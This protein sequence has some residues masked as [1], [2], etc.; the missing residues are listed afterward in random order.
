MEKTEPSLC[1]LCGEPLPHT[2]TMEDIRNSA[3]YWTLATA[4]L[5]ELAEELSAINKKPRPRRK[6]K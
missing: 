5:R 4:P 6:K 1:R 2:H 3:L